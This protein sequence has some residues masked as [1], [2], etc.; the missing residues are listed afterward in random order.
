M[1]AAPPRICVVGSCNVDLTFRAARL[2]RPGETLPAHSVL[3]GHGG[4]GANQAVM[5][6]RL[7]ARVALI[8]R[9]GRDSFGEQALAH[10][11]AEGI[12]TTHVGTDAERPTGTAA[13]LVDDRA[14]NCILVVAGA[15]AGVS[16]DDVGAAESALERAGAV[17][18]QLETPLDATLAAFRLARAHRVMTFLNP[19]P[20]ADLPDELLQLTDVLMPNEREAERLTGLPVEMVDQAEAAARALRRRG[21]QTVLITLG[22]RGVVVAGGERCEPVA[23]V[24]VAAVDTTGAGDAFIGALAVFLLEGGELFETARRAAAVAALAVTRPG[25]QGAFPTRAEVT[26]FLASHS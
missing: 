3:M 1:S 22:E 20:A 21:P 4:K 15:N 17:L 26:A 16:P 24:P 5:A 12:D 23:A 13:I 25:A 10:Y 19:A 14:N 9:V 7:G 8:G 6:A 11:R 2:P 18:C